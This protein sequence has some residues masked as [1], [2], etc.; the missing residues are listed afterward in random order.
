MIVLARWIVILCVALLL[1]AALIILASV[2][3]PVIFIRSVL[4]V[5]VGSGLLRMYWDGPG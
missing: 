4:T 5:V 1:G 2:I 3:L